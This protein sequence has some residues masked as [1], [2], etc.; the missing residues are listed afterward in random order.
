MRPAAGDAGSPAGRH[1]DADGRPAVISIAAPPARSVARLVLVLALC[2]G[3]LY[4]L[5]LTRGVLKIVAIAVFTAIALGPLVDLMQHTG[6]RRGWSIGAVYVALVLIVAGA[7]IAVVP[8]STS[9]V[10]RL[11]RDGQH[12]VTHLRRDPTFKRYDE[13]YHITAKLQDQL[14][15]LPQRASALSGPLRDVTVG[16]FGFITTLVTVL[17]IAFLLLLNGRRHAD[18]ALGALPV[19]HA[20]RWRRLLPQVYAAV[21][22]YVLGNLAISAIA[23]ACAWLALSV[24][25]IPFA[26]PLALLVAFLDLIPMIGATLA[27]AGVALVALL[28]SPIACLIWLAYAFVYQQAENYVI[29]PLVYRRAVEVNPLVTIIAVMVG[30]TLL[31]LLGSLLAIPVA[32]ALQL[33]VGEFR[34]PERSAALG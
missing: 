1:P 15:R 19:R 9:Q 12:A 33:I 30:G 4:L 20:V 2:V 18:W 23:G 32:A 21:S 26:L 16:V 17:S 31:G 29:Q 22:R 28:V 27:A 5:Y 24:L 6:L 7:G 14:G 13:R 8:S 11:S 34:Q 3:T 10:Q 25:G